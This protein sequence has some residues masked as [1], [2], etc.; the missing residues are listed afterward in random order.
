VE[1]LTEVTLFFNFVQYR[2]CFMFGCIF[3]YHM[4]YSDVLTLIH[5]YYLLFLSMI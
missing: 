3:Y 1:V 2:M 5:I 4:Y